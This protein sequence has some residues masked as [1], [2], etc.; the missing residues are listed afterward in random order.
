MVV[1]ADHPRPM[2]AD[3]CMTVHVYPLPPPL[4][5]SHSQHRLIHTC[6]FKPQPNMDGA[7]TFTHVCVD[8][9]Q[10]VLEHHRPFQ[11]DP[12]IHTCVDS[13]QTVLEHHRCNSHKIYVQ[14]GCMR[15]TVEKLGLTTIL[16]VCDSLSPSAYPHP[17]RSWQFASAA[18]KTFSCQA[19]ANR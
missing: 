16:L 18:Y 1:E 11:K 8:S 14:L 17:S 5:I 4:I 9:S 2:W 12:F 3:A 6:Q 10:T 13:S 15:Y 7:L 19:T